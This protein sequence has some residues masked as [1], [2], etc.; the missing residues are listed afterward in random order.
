MKRVLTLLSLFYILPV[1]AQLTGRVL[2]KE[3]G[4]PLIGAHLRIADSYY[5]AVSGPDGGFQF[6][7]IAEGQY[8]LIVS[9]IGYKHDTMEVKLPTTESIDIALQRSNVLSEALLIQSTRVSAEDPFASSSLSQEEIEKQN[10]GADF[11]ILMTWTPSVVTTSDAGAGVGYTGIRIRGSDATRINVTVNGIPINDAESQGTFWVNMPDMA[12]ST[13][14]L[15][16]QRGV[17]T[18]T[19]GAAAFGAS[20]NL[21]TTTLEAKP[22]GQLSNSYGSF[23]TRKHSLRFGSGLLGGKWAFDGRLSKISSDGYIDRSASDLRSYYLSGGYYGEKSI[24]KFVHFSGKEHTQQAW[25]GTPESRI[26]NDV[27]A[28]NTHA[29]N[30]G[31]SDEQR[32]NL[33]NSGRT[34]NHYRYDNEV[35][36][37][38]QDHYQLHFSHQFNNR[39]HLNASLHYTDGQGFFEQF[40]EDDDLADYQFKP[41]I[42]GSDTVTTTDLIRRR[43]LDNDFYGMTFSFGHQHGRVL[44]TFGGGA[45]QYVGDHFG[46]VIWARFSSNS[47]IR[48][49]FYENDAVKNDGNLYLKTQVQLNNKW[50][51]FTDFQYRA[52]YYKTA[53]KDIDQRQIN[54]KNEF[55]FFNPKA[56]FSFKPNNAN[57]FYA[58]VAVAHREPVR[59]DFIDAPAGETPKAEE[60]IDYE[61]GYRRNTK[62]YFFGANLYYMDYTDQLVLTGELNDVG[63][64]VRQ[65]VA[66]SYRGGIELEMNWL[67]HKRI[68]W[69]WNA[70]FS[71]NR[72][73][74]YEEAVQDYDNGTVVR[75]TFKN[76]AISFSPD[77]VAGSQ[78]LFKPIEQLEL[79]LLTK[80]VGEQYLDNTE[81]SDRQIPA[82][83]VNDIRISY[84]VKQKLFKE[85]RWS[86]LV[87]NV[88]DETYSSNGYTYS[89][90]YGSTITENFYY[91][92][93][94]IHFLAGLTLAF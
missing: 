44:T 2:D 59:N 69:G 25:Y 35:D 41:V 8:K 57:Q 50:T 47:D 16:I 55:G 91:P 28:M 60:M 78:L 6:Q 67:L 86:L 85:M 19:N 89:Y 32:A 42:I 79:A 37:Y 33:L 92:Q 58:S 84:E 23:N 94:G 76:T 65:N 64:S 7:G 72:I 74:S 77:V 9:Y 75:T 46:E 51:A 82:Y 68:S 62:K 81:N 43:W 11:P 26:N 1:C 80:Y 83:L 14:S 30:S 38:Q 48:D 18:S 5:L 21:Q 40:R 87:N 93:A 17:G 52:I 20:I 27:E 36:D 29:D 66:S 54:S 3:S 73:K 63:S 56:G 31:Y 49:R 71:Q 61:A 53:G 34:Y 88:L 22:Y 70:T 24:L 90:I 4:E 10:L 15:Q 13:Q 12:G 39:M 45:N